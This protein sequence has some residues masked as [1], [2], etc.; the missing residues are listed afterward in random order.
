MSSIK[1]DRESAVFPTTAV[2]SLEHRPVKYSLGIPKIDVVFCEVRACLLLS[3]HAKSIS[4][5]FSLI[6][7]QVY[8]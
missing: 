6:G 1:T 8:V 2:D 7:I 5:A 3:S 4:C